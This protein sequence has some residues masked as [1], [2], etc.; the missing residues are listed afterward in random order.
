MVVIMLVQL[1]TARVTLDALGVIDYGIYN[2]VGAFIVIFTFI[3][4]PINTATQRFLNYEYGLSEKG[5]VELVYN[6][7]CYIYILFALILVILCETI[8]LWYLNNKMQIPDDRMYAAR[9]S[10]QL[11]IV[12][13]AFTLLKTP[14]NALILAN[15]KMS[16]YA[17]ISIVEAILRLANAVMLQWFMIDKLILYSFNHVV[18]ELILLA[19]LNIYCVRKFKKIRFKRLWDADRFKDILN[20]SGWSLFG[21]MAGASSKQGLNILLNL[22]FGVAINAAMGIAQQISTAI[23]QFVTNFQTAFRPQIVKYYASRDLDALKT[24]IINSS[25]Y[26]YLLLFLVVCPFCF[27]SSYV[28]KL[29]LGIPPHYASEFTICFLIYAL[30]ESLAAPLWMAIQ[31]TGKIKKYQIL[32]SLLVSL[33]IV[34]SYIF[35]KLGFYPLVVIEIKCLID[36]FICTY[37][38]LASLSN[39]TRSPLE[40]SPMVFS[41][42]HIIPTLSITFTRVSSSG[43]R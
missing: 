24:L 28:L 26:S 40:L 31:A 22:F 32:V 42:C 6:L 12:T 1:Y 5:Q 38:F 39:H 7:S 37:I 20:F 18:I 17:Y 41:V 43:S 27:N 13:L 25:K 8:G 23:N 30:I 11:Y 2:I 14:S 16:Y 34:I 15:E 33:N 9:I 19:C 35:L 3:S 4:G 36:I 29:W 21:S 10:Y